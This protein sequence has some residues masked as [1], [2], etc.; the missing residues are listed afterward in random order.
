MTSTTKIS[1]FFY[2]TPPF[3]YQYDA[4]SLSWVRFWSTPTLFF[5]PQCRRRMNIAPNS[6]QNNAAASLFKS[7]N[8]C[9]TLRSETDIIP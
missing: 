2:H 7:A 8:L 9:Q 5:A 1:E 6:K 3:L 4:T